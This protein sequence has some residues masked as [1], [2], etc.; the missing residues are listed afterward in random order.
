MDLVFLKI[1][2]KSHCVIARSMQVSM[3]IFKF[4]DLVL[5]FCILYQWWVLF[6]R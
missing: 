3:V 6:F 5:G 1:V 2:P 4:I